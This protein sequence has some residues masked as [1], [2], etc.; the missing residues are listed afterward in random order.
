MPYHLLFLSGQEAADT[1]LQRVLEREYSR[2]VCARGD[3]ALE[4]IKA[5]QP[6]L[7]ILDLE[8]G[9][10]EGLTFLRVLRETSRGKDL[11]VIVLSDR[12]TDESV[13]AAFEYGA[14][15]FMKRPVD[16]EELLARA[17]VI[18]RRNRERLDHWGTPLTVGEI[19]IDP[20]QRLCLVKGRRVS[21][22]PRE[23]ELLE[24]LMRKAGRVLRRSYLLENV[25]GMSSMAQT[26]AVDMVIS[27]LRQKLGKRAGVL[28]ETV[29]KLGYSLRTP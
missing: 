19:E 22:R 27:R 15:D 24:I 16:P 9:D 10:M 18:L 17:R 26:R 29:T 4:E 25:W 3:E 2:R 21:L 8:L 5:F 28:I 12:K 7:L 11:P 13:G 14:E 1:D 23:F 6:D 20:S